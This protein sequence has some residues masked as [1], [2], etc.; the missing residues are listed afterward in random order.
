[1]V[2]DLAVGR[3]I[4]SRE[5]LGLATG[6]DFP[7]ALAG[8][9]AMARLGGPLVLGEGNTSAMDAWLAGVGDGC[10]EVE[11]FGSS[12][13]VPDAFATSVLGALRSR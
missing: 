6:K 10:L 3:G 12:T 5:R 8:G 7:D 2:A 13:V 4:L 1:M 9:V 11:V